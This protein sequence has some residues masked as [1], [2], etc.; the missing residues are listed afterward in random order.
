MLD[1]PKHLGECS[2]VAL[3][4]LRRQIAREALCLRDWVRE[5]PVPLPAAAL[6]SSLISLFVHIVT[7]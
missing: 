4:G 2:H 3:T 6:G 7:P 1:R 5:S